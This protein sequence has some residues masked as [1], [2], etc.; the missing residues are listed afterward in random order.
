[1]QDLPKQL[2][3]LFW[4]SFLILFISFFLFFFSSFSFLLIDFLCKVGIV[5]EN[6]GFYQVSIS[7]RTGALF[8]VVMSQ[9][10]PGLMSVLLTC[11]VSL[12]F[13]FSLNLLMDLFIYLFIIVPIERSLLIREQSNGMYGVGSYFFGKVARFFSSLELFIIQI[14]IKKYFFFKII[15]DFLLKY[16]F[17]Y[18]I[19]L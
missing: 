15:V 9:V 17:L 2:S 18:F 1:V 16:Y 13:S 3:C 7:N 6:L 19:V 11:K 12:F 14:I 10:M 4:Y 5:Y 8:F